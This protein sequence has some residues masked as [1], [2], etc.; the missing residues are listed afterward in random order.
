MRRP[1]TFP[2]GGRSFICQRC[3]ADVWRPE[4][5]RLDNNICLNCW[6]GTAVKEIVR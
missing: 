2:R 4:S 1:T 6:H 3:G 5:D